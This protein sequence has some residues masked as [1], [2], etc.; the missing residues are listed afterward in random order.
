ME[1]ILRVVCMKT[2]M[3][4]GVP[5]SVL[6]ALTTPSTGNQGSYIASLVGEGNPFWA[7]PTI[8]PGRVIGADFTD[9]PLASL[10]PSENL[11]LVA[12]I[13]AAPEDVLTYQAP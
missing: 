8:P 7:W 6:A 12:G 5:T 4:A 1:G 3:I 10:D 11:L 13:T 9:A 2:V